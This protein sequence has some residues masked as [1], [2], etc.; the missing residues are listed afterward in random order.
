MILYRPVG[1]EEL[2]LIRKSGFRAFPPRLP[3]QPYFYPVLHKEYAVQIARDWNIHD[4]RSGFAG[5]VTEFEMD[6]KFI[7]RYEVRTVGQAG[8]HE[9]FWIPAE[10]LEEFNRHIMGIIRVKEAFYGDR[11]AGEK[12]ADFPL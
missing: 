2:H 9:E 11:Y 8:L 6:D 5:F 7:R 10:E 12:E 4:P 3:W 1:Y